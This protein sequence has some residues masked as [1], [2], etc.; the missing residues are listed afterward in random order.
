[1]EDD[2]RFAQV[3]R[4]GDTAQAARMLRAAPG[5]ARPDGEAGDPVALA[6]R[7]GRLEVLRLLIEAGGLPRAEGDHRDMPTALMAAA[8]AGHA[9]AVGLLLESGAD[10]ALRDRAGRTAADLAAEAGHATLAQRL[11]TA[12]EAERIVW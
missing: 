12:A 8:A 2:A 10:P 5:L 3:V 11:K 4:D 6:A 7:H 1:M 9:D